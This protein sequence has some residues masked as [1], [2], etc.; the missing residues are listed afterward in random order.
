MKS[1]RDNMPE[2]LKYLTAPLLRNKLIYNSEFCHYYKLLGERETLSQEAIIEYQ[3]NQ[4][5]AILIHAFVNVSYYRDL[6]NKVSFDPYKFSD[7][8][9]VEAIPF[10]TREL[11]IKNFDKLTSTKKS[12]NGYYVGYTGGST[13]KPLEFLL[14][15]DS[16]F[17]ENAFIYYFRKKAGYTF[18]D[19]VATFRY[20]GPGKLLWR[21]SPMYRE[22]TFSN[23][24]LSKI[25]IKKYAE[26]INK[27]QPQYLNGYLSAIWY[28]SKLL[29]ENNIKLDFK[30]KG[31]FLISENPNAEQREFIEKY[32]NAKSF[33]FYG[34]SERVV[35][36]E[37]VKPGSYVFDPC[38]GYTEQIQVKENEYAIVGTGFLNKTMPFIRYKTDDTC[39]P[40]KKYFKITGKRNSNMGLYGINN[41]FLTDTGF[42]MGLEAFQ[43][44]LTYQ[45][46]QDKK[47]KADMLIIVNKSFQNGELK[48]IKKE[49]DNETKGVIDI[50][51]KVIDNMVLT[52]HG[53]FQKYISRIPAI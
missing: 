49:I 3:F 4:L 42:Y 29:E 41:E 30:L 43:N 13:G 39:V 5:K 45:F 17:R 6:F 1:V 10:L 32:F 50:N 12:S 35:I 37:E 18:S 23:A 14:D 48:T 8:K 51:I 16:I 2:S 21:S 7:F 22:V 44:I 26:R 15:Y 34:H 36:A 46:F 9:Q 53:K 27:L 25:T 28:F 19:R 31:I 11:V 24:R 33:T 38:Y 20:L 47:G 52:E 40:E